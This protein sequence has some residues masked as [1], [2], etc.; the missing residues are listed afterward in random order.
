MQGAGE[1]DLE[2]RHDDLRSQQCEVC[3]ASGGSQ[4]RDCQEGR[5]ALTIANSVKGKSRLDLGFDW[6]SGRRGEQGLA[7]W[8][9][10]EDQ[11]TVVGAEDCHY[12]S[13]VWV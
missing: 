10:S 4:G 8:Q 2:K 11:R 6:K 1:G 7:L 3:S 13:R 9:W 5:G 12:L